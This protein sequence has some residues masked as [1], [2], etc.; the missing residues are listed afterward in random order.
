MG[1]AVALCRA[2]V[3]GR[4]GL[5]LARERPGFAA[6]LQ[7]PA[8]YRKGDLGIGAAGQR[9]HWGRPAAHDDLRG[10][11]PAPRCLVINDGLTLPERLATC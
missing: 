5:N 3:A 9:G 7:K 8:A 4:F 10:V 2:A 11:C 6:A 1:A